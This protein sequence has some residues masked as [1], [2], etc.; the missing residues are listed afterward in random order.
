M[1]V[2]GGEEKWGRG[3]VAGNRDEN[4]FIYHFFVS[5]F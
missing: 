1:C 5:R 2:V 4:F 3:G